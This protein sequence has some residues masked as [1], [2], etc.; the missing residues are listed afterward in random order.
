[1]L[2]MTSALSLIPFIL[3]A[4][5]ALRL[6]IT[7]EGYESDASRRTPELVFAAVATIYTL[8]LLFAAG[9]R[10]MLVSFVIYAPGTALFAMARREQRRRV[11]SGSEMAIF[12][13]SVI[14]AAVGVVAIAAG[15]ITI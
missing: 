15:W 6:A 3:A 10:Y 4:G 12:A 1:A 2:N 14:L 7:R 5:Y 8:F 9:P 11:F 13:V